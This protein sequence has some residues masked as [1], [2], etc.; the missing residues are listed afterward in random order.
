MKSSVITRAMSC[1]GS[2]R[3]VA[4]DSTAIVARAHEIHNTAKTMTAAMGRALT[5]CSLIGCLLKNKTDSATLQICG[6]GPAGKIVCISDYKGNVRGW[7]ENPDA[8]LP[9]NA[10]GK[11]DV[12]GAVGAGTLTVIKD[13]GEAE[14]YCGMIDLVSGE[15]A[16]DITQYF[17]V[18]EQTPTVC[19]LG[20]LANT[21]CSC[22]AAGGF[23]LQLLPGYDPE[24]IDT[25]EKNIAALPPVSTMVESG[26]T[27]EQMISAI[28]AGIPFDI[29]D[30]ID[31]AYT[32]N[33]DRERYARALLTLG[34]DQLAELIAGGENVETRC[35]YC[36]ATH[37]FTVEDIQNMISA[38]DGQSEN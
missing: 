29:F 12:G 28:L 37:V 27:G 10:K 22:R 35:R 6:D 36:H 23:L 11:L 21:D 2:I 17:A 20:V 25:V 5:A 31:T 15:I 14:P 32:C 18:S 38:L 7:A 3:V 9:P 26:M 16:D 1:D 4:T 19:A 33:C 24:L 30:E 8:E 13:M 34:R